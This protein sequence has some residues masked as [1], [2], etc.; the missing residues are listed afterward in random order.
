M[1]KKRAVLGTQV[2]WRYARSRS[3]RTITRVSYQ[4]SGSSFLVRGKICGHCTGL[5][6]G[7]V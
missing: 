1:Q 7:R 5:N 6:K 4:V 3:I 2:L